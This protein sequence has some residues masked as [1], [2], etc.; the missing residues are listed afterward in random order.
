MPLYFRDLPDVVAELAANAQGNWCNTAF[1][2]T[3]TSTKY[4]KEYF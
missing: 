3:G 4:P 1:S 2:P